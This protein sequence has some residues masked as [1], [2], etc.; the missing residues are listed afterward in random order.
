VPFVFR[1]LR[2]PGPSAIRIRGALAHELEFPVAQ[3]RELPRRSL[4]AD[5]HC[6]TGWSAVAL[7]WSGVP[8]RTLYQVV[9]LPEAEPQ[10]AIT[11]VLFRGA[12]GYRATLT[13]EDA[14][15]EDVL[16]ADELD[17]RPL[18]VSHGA[19]VRLL[20]PKQYGYKSTKHLCAIE[21]HSAEPAERDPKRL[22]RVV[23]R[24]LAP[25][26]RARVWPEERHR[27]LPAWSIRAL[28]RGMIAPSVWYWNRDG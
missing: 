26:S 13:L 5:F 17:D 9:I 16:L 2:R 6:V 12:D 14:L 23:E 7:H 4:V 3:L 25:H 18:C 1:P 19:P 10:P 20:S 22:R 8:F 24:A 15:D 28:Y 21:L 11:H 27:L